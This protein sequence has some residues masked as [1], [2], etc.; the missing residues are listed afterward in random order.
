MTN[1]DTDYYALR[2]HADGPQ[3][4]VRETQSKTKTKHP[5]SY[6]CALFI[7]NWLVFNAIAQKETDNT[8]Q[9]SNLPQRCVFVCLYCMPNHSWRTKEKKK[10][11]MTFFC[12]FLMFLLFFLG[13]FRF[14]SHHFLQVD[15]TSSPSAPS[16]IR[17][18]NRYFSLWLFL[19]SIAFSLSLSLS[20]P[21]FVGMLVLSCMY[22]NVDFMKKSKETHLHFFHLL[23]Y[24]NAD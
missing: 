8:T 3:R 17:Y 20:L 14:W 24:Y 16:L 21:F 10:W 12:F 13:L 2:E 9:N 7:G 1:S 5:E 11:K 19:Y 6:G 23:L 4:K 15:P 18:H 22:A